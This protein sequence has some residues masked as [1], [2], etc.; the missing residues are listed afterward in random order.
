MTHTHTRSSSTACAAAGAMHTTARLG[1]IAMAGATLVAAAAALLWSGQA[2]AEEVTTEAQQVD[3]STLSEEAVN[4]QW[5]DVGSTGIGLALGAAEANPLGIV[6]LGLKVAT[7]NNIKNA[8]ELEQPALWSAYGALGWGAAANNLCVIAAIATGGAGAAICPLIGLA[9]GLG[10]YSADEEARNRATF[11]AMCKDARKTQ[12]AL[13]CV[14][15]PPA[16]S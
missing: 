7:Y 1:R 10:T 3:M 14:Y 9:T 4:G 13:E 16:K 12:P 6:T 11:D 8:P 15:T 5:A 2:H